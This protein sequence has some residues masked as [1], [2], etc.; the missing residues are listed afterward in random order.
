MPIKEPAGTSKIHDVFGGL[1][2]GIILAIKTISLASLL[3]A[4]VLAPYAS[5]GIGTALLGALILGILIT[6][7]SSY[8]GMIGSPQEAPIAILA[9]A[10]A[11][12]IATMPPA[13]SRDSIFATVL[14]AIVITSLLGG[15]IFLTLGTFKLGG[16]IRYMP[17]P[18]V[19]GF[20]AGAGWLLFKG[21]IQLM[22]NTPL[23]IFHLEGLLRPDNILRWLP[24]VLF[25]VI[26]LIAISRIP[27]YL[28]T[29]VALVIGVVLFYSVLALSRTSVAQAGA[30]GWMLGPFVTDSDAPQFNLNLISQ[31]YWPA[32]LSHAGNFLAVMIS[33]VI[34]LLLNASSVEVATERDL[35]LNRELQ[36]A[37]AGNLFSALFGGLIG[38]QSLSLT[39]MAHKMGGRQRIAGLLSAL[40]CGLVLLLGTTA[41]TYMP[42]V[43]LGGLL[44]ML[45]LSLMAQ[46]LVLSFMKLPLLDYLIIL[47][48]LFVIAIFGFLEGVTVGIL[49]ALVL[50]IIDYSRVNVVKHALTGATQRSS[51]TR[52]KRER[53]ILDHEGSQLYILQLQGY[54]FFG[55]ANGLLNQIRGRIESNSGHPVRYVL[56]DFRQVTGLD[57]SATFSFV[58]L[59]QLAQRTGT[60][61]VFTH[62]APAMRAQLAQIGILQ[63]GE[64]GIREFPDMDHGVEWC[65]SMIVQHALHASSE[66]SPTLSGQLREAY[67][68]LDVDRLMQY[69]ER[70]EVQAG[71]VLMH[72]GDAPDEMYFI[73]SGRVTAQLERPHQKPTRLQTM[74]GQ[75]VVGEIGLY[76]GTRRTASVI[77]EEPS[78]LYRLTME[79]LQ[80]MKYQDP[81]LAAALHEHIARLMAERLVHVINSLEAVLR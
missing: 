57:S 78:V 15:I 76:L 1:V 42:R 20:M 7:V 75:N 32:L 63:T 17:Y 79:A 22:T 68:N 4:G 67:P 33:G 64:T 69:L 18:V 70:V 9:T 14:A 45:G 72:Q 29:P 47:L 43:V 21:S 30:E 73:E 28:V 74:A 50:F 46:W 37:G 62:L 5:F 41:L 55:T 8:A 53:E 13:A 16:L 26:L 77:A 59:K 56:L 58:K 6:L 61:V 44:A 38:F 48:I 25:G 2:A 71:S 39:M 35:D 24:G 34:A 10:C 60:A 51:I 19:G 31:I 66:H 80:R 52:S 81:Q 27:H 12:M 49:A 23:D 65:E 54:I 40:V 3:F 11:A 36:A